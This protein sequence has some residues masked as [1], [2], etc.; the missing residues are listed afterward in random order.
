MSKIIIDHDAAIDD[1][2]AVTLQILN[3]PNNIKAITLLPADSYALPAV[4]VMERLKEY[5]FP[6]LEILDYHK[7]RGNQI[8]CL[9]QIMLFAYL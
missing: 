2:I 8:N 3:S 1:I 5:F 4:Y 6:K 9:N 7:P